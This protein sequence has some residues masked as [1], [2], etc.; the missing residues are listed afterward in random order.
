MRTNSVDEPIP[1]GAI[2]I[3]ATEYPNDE[4]LLVS[5]GAFNQVEEEVMRLTNRLAGSGQRRL[6]PLPLG[7]NMKLSRGSHE[8]RNSALIPGRRSCRACRAESSIGHR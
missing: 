3:S 2:L 8:G 6:L 4:Q 5:T 7:L 1:R